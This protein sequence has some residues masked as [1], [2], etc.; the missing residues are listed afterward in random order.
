MTEGTP[1]KVAFPILLSKAII[2]LLGKQHQWHD[3]KSAQIKHQGRKRNWNQIKK[4]PGS[5]LLIPTPKRGLRGRVTFWQRRPLYTTR[6]AGT[7]GAFPPLLVQRKENKM[8]V[9]QIQSR[10]LLPIQIKGGRQGA[11]ALVHHYLTNAEGILQ[12][13]LPMRPGHTAIVQNS[14]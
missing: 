10:N 8:P 14:D 5:I 12:Y 11:N 2:W 1:N 6:N 13:L 4:I 7:R 9:S 3:Y